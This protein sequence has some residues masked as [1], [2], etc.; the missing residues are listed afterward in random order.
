VKPKD[1]KVGGYRASRSL[2]NARVYKIEQFR[3]HTLLKDDFTLDFLLKAFGDDV[4]EAID[5]YD[6]FVGKDG[7]LTKLTRHVNKSLGVDTYLPALHPGAE[8][9][10]QINANKLKAMSSCGSPSRTVSSMPPGAHSDF[11]LPDQMMTKTGE[12][13]VGGGSKP[14]D[15]FKYTG[16]SS[17]AKKHQ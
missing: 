8:A 11:K 6:M 16:P 1:I 10:D 17:Y 4:I 9:E 13:S 7:D 12:S 15:E 5:A 3:K 14:A 2:L